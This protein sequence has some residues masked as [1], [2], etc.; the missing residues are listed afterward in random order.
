MNIQ[1][2][3]NLLSDSNWVKQN[4]EIDTERPLAEKGYEKLTNSISKILKGSIKK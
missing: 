3:T 4:S 2:V 1:K